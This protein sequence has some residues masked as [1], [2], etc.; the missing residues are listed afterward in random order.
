[1]MA[2]AAGGSGSEGAT[3]TTATT[4]NAADGIEKQ[5]WR[6]RQRRQTW[7]TA[8]RGGWQW[9]RER[10]ALMSEEALK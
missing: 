6:G 2:N 10:T 5:R 8:E 7:Q 9:K 3:S 4:A 1:M